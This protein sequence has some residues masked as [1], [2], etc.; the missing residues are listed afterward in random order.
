MKRFNTRKT[1]R[2]HLQQVRKDRLRVAFVPT[3][4]ALHQG[5]ITLIHHARTLADVVVCSIFVN[6]TQFNDPED[7]K[8]YPRPI[9]TD[10]RLLQEAG[11]HVL[12][13]PEVSEMY[14][15]DEHWHMDL[16]RLDEILE[17]SHRPGHFQGVTQVVKKLFD[18]VQ[19]DIACFGQKDFQQF[20]VVERLVAQFQL[21]VKLAMVPTVREPDGLAMS[22]RN[23][24][25]SATGR[26][27][28]LA[29]YRALL[30]IKTDMTAKAPSTLREEAI[31]FLESSPGVQVEYVALCDAQTLETIDEFTETRS[32]V[33]LVAAWVDG[34][35]LIDNML[36]N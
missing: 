31:R 12:F 24:R 25:L 35:R 1:L 15:P 9:D 10:I 18:I 13:Q 2:H 17:A 19:P 34:V 22:S 20:K 29:L 32:S 16:G 14:G 27:Q 33:A 36:L 28:A 6:P 7:L 5:H 3:M 11:C 23:V 26:Q 30:W 21:P 8:K 4:G